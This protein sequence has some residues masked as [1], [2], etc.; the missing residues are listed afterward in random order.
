MVPL[1]KRTVT[2]GRAIRLYCIR[3]CGGQASAVVGCDGDE[4]ARKKG[5]SPCGFHTHRLGRGRPSVRL[6]RKFCLSC[7]GGKSDFVRDCLTTT[8]SLY[9]FRMGKNPNRTRTGVRQCQENIETEHVK[10]IFT[11][12]IQ[13]SLPGTEDASLRGP[14]S[15]LHTN[16]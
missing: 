5:F 10:G 7:Q 8:C 1:E 11:P 9:P 13:R 3:C 14:E 16:C 15:N 12:C 4:S 2:P 6:I